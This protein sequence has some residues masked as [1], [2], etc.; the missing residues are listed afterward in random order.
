MKGLARS[1]CWWPGLDNDIEKFV[2]GCRACNLA[3]PDPRKSKLS[4]WPQAK[5]N[6]KR[7]HV[8][9]F[10][11]V[12]GRNFLILIDAFS[13]WIEVFLM[14]S[15]DS[16]SVLEKL[17]EVF[18]RFGIPKT[19][20][21]D[22]GRQFVSFE[23]ENFCKR[24]GIVH[25]TSAPYHPET[26]G[27]AENA[28]GMI[29]RGL[30]KMLSDTKNCKET[31]TLLS[32]Y[33]LGYRNAVHSSTGESPAVLML[34]R[35]VRIRLDMLKPNDRSASS[36]ARD[37][38][39]RYHGGKRLQNFAEGEKVYV[40]DYRQVNKKK[41]IEAV[42]LNYEGKKVYRCEV[43]SGKVWRRHVDQIK[44]RELEQIDPSE[45]VAPQEQKVEE[46]PVAIAA[47]AND[48][49]NYPGSRPPECV[50]SRPRDSGTREPVVVGGMALESAVAPVTASMMPA[51]QDSKSTRDRDRPESAECVAEAKEPGSGVGVRPRRNVKPPERYGFPTGVEVC[52]VSAPPSGD[53][54]QSRLIRNLVR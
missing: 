16:Q 46:S 22:N 20:V 7:V 11:P 3:S 35:R 30:I 50:K 25:K 15:T 24:N 5:E 32:R 39:V 49:D 17:R 54:Q 42:V 51:I 48:A 34:N 6:F 19:I 12:G 13:K 44:A 41:W 37:H 29:K 40:R 45:V 10:G 53:L 8:D 2:K 14:D 21:S 52:D 4:L 33:M 9:L 18:A 26:N 28:V 43:E 47:S 1:T 23:F 36:R 38:L 27:A 31:S